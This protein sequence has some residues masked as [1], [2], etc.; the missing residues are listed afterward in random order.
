MERLAQ[1]WGHCAV[2]YVLDATGADRC[3]LVVDLTRV[4][5]LTRLYAAGVV[6]RGMELHSPAHDHIQMT[7]EI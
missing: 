4:A 3:G 7:C 5:M 6:P 1:V 2:H